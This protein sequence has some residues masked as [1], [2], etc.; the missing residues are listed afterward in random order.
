VRV[1]HAVTQCLDWTVPNPD[2]GDRHFRDKGQPSMRLSRLIRSG[3]LSSRKIYG[4]VYG[5]QD[6]GSFS[7]NSLAA[8]RREVTCGNCPKRNW[9]HYMRKDA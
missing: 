1:G 4:G 2:L 7:E 8:E 6:N 9:T 3:T 5:G